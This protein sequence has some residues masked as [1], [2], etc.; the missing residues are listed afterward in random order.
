MCT[1]HHTM[2][3]KGRKQYRVWVL[4]SRS[5]EDSASKYSTLTLVSEWELFLSVLRDARGYSPG[6]LLRTYPLFSPANT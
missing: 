2:M 1:L 6:L 5:A 4:A 3:A